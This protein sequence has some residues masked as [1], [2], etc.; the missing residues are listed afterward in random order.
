MNLLTVVLLCHNRPAYAR[1]SIESILNQSIPNFKFIISDNSTNSDVSNLVKNKYPFLEYKSWYPGTSAIDH[2]RN[3][4]SLV[5]TP[6]FVMFHDDDIMEPDYVT[7]ILRQFSSNPYAAAVATNGTMINPNGD[8]IKNVIGSINV[9]DSNKD[10]I[11]FHHKNKFLAQYLAGDF[12]GAANFSSYAY[13]T[14]LIKGIYPD[15]SKCRYFFDTIFLT[16]LLDRG[17]II[18][19]NKPLVKVRSHES[20]IS[21]SCGVRDYKSFVS[22]ISKKFG[23][24]IKSIYINE[25]HF[26]HLYVSLEKR[27]R[28]YPAPVLKYLFLTFPQLFVSSS[29]FRRRFWNKS[30]NIL[31]SR[32]RT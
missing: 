8:L 30:I 31:Y 2:F 20:T 12:G 17:P 23:S 10:E 13:N 4:I 28:G 24:K 22:F 3:V 18:W 1:E 21:S 16:Q 29:S 9:F 27:G 19:I 7:T 25:Y 5:S 14:D 6:Y 26:T 32:F 15:L 11:I